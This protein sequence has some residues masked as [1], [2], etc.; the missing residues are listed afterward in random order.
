MVIPPKIPEFV[1]HRHED[2]VPGDSVFF[3][4]PTPGSPG[5]MMSREAAVEKRAHALEK[6]EFEEALKAETAKVDKAKAIAK[7]ALE[8]M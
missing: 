8:D 5:K 1:P 2:L 3:E 4:R 6:E 7:K